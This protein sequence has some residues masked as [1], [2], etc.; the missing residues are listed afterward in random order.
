MRPTICN[1]SLSLFPSHPS[2]LMFYNCYLSWIILL[3]LWTN[4][5]LDLS[6]CIKKY[7]FFSF[8]ASL[9]VHANFRWSFC[10]CHVVLRDSHAPMKLGFDI[11][12]SQH[13]F[14]VNYGNIYQPS[15][16]ICAFIAPKV[17]LAFQLTS[18]QRKISL[19][20]IF[21]KYYFLD[22]GTQTDIQNTHRD[23]QT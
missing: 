8:F 22:T 1:L 4:P 21:E 5:T 15:F 14:L 20:V 19:Q 6:L 23:T 7:L 3:N 13:F 10:A 11:T 2:F 17:K 16:D 18:L 9:K 12:A